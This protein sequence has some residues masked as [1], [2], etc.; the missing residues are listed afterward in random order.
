MSP[1]A[2]AVAVF[3]GFVALAGFRMWLTYRRSNDVDG[4]LAKV[5]ELVDA[6]NN[7]AGKIESELTPRLESL[8]AGQLTLSNKVESAKVTQMRRR[9][10]GR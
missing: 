3:W 4:K 1:L 5:R 9:E 8:E 2:A 6:A 7:R 10:W